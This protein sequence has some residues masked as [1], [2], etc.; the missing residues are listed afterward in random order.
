MPSEHSTSG[1]ERSVEDFQTAL[2]IIEECDWAEKRVAVHPDITVEI[3][4]I[5]HHKDMIELSSRLF[6][7]ANYRYLSD[8]NGEYVFRYEGGELDAE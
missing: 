3:D 5:P 2:S 1:T 4:E 7:E 8:Y 6:E